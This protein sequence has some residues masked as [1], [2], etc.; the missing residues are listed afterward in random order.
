MRDPEGR[1]KRRAARSARTAEE[2]PSPHNL[3]KKK[4]TTDVEKV[5]KAEAKRRARRL[6]NL[7][8]AQR[9]RDGLA[10]FD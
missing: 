6:R 7:E 4:T 5:S 10:R 2:G 9:A 1:A 3:G 8:R